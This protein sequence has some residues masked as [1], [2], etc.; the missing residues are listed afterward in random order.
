[1]FFSREKEIT[2]LSNLLKKPGHAALIYG[3]R[4][5]GKTE[6]IKHIST[7]HNL[8]YYECIKDTL[9]ENVRLFVNECKRNGINIPEYANFSSFIEVFDYLNSLDKHFLVAIDEYQYLKELN[10]TSVVDS[11]FQ[12]IIDRYISNLNLIIS[13]S[14]ISM[15]K[16]LLVEG[17]PLYGRFSLTINL[18]ELNY[19]EVSQFYEDLSIRDKVAFYA[20]FGGSPFI[21]KQIEPKLTLKENI[22]NTFLKEGS[23]IYNYADNVLISDAV[24]ELQARRLLLALS[25]SKK[26]YSELLAIL[27]KEK[28]GVFNRSLKSLQDIE[29]V[30]KN[31]PINKTDDPKKTSYEIAD[32]VIRFYYTYVYKNKSRLA[33]LGP[34]L[35]Y[36][37]Y[38]E[39]TINNYVSYRFESLVRDYFSLKAKNGSLKGIRNIGTYYYDDQHNKTN[40]EFDVALDIKDGYAIYEVKYL[41]TPLTKQ[42]ILEEVKQIKQIEE[43]N[44]LKI[45]FISISGFKEP[46]SG[47]E[48]INGEDLYSF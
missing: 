5:V 7:N 13:G 40:G 26:K 21:N 20:V 41:K 24:N 30:K 4:R 46:V 2:A 17:N 47:Y 14:A 35:F 8:L 45:G 36:E 27:D 19:C 16:D 29:I 42:Q 12:T 37:E 6:L 3:K 32:N 28:S 38:I 10:S 25:N 11:M 1:M 31:S 23:G 48:L 44:V 43:I 18:P 15:M 34:T 33:I 22:I 39:P 9:K